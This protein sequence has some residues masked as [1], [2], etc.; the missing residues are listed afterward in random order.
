MDTTWRDRAA[1]KGKQ[2]LFFAV[3]C[4]DQYSKISRLR[5]ESDPY[6]YAR[7]ICA[8]CPVRRECL[9]FALNL[10][11]SGQQVDGMWGG[12][13]ERERRKIDGRAYTKRQAS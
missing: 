7:T 9:D 10:A 5:A 12:L 3:A 11:R 8:E 13:D 2:K 6:A 1:C 4:G